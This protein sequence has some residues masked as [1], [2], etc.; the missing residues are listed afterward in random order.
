MI[1]LLNDRVLWKKHKQEGVGCFWGYRD[2]TRRNSGK[3]QSE[4]DSYTSFH[5][6][7]ANSEEFLQIYEICRIVI[8]RK[9]CPLLF[10][11]AKVGFYQTK[12]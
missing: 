4:W 7:L 9:I 8:E 6:D 5:V 12:W 11:K 10:F 2:C 1:R 3:S